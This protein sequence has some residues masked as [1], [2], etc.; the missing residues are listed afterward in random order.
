MRSL[1]SALRAVA[2]FAWGGNVQ[3]PLALIACGFFW[4]MV[5][6]AIGVVGTSFVVVINFPILFM[7]VIAVIVGALVNMMLTMAIFSDRLRMKCSA[8]MKDYEEELEMWV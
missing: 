7:N 3:S 2:L 6:C 1:S 8:P 4:S 5:T